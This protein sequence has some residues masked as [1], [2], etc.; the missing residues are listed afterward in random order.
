MSN[1]DDNNVVQVGAL[2]LDRDQRVLHAAIPNGSKLTIAVGQS[3]CG[4]SS[5]IKIS[6][7][8]L[9]VEW[10]DTKTRLSVNV[11]DAEHIT[12]YDLQW[13]TPFSPSSIHYLKD[14]IDLNGG[15]HW[16]GGPEL[17]NQTFPIDDSAYGM[18]PYV[19]GDVNNYG[20][21]GSGIERF[22]L[23]SN[24]M[25]VYVPQEVP[26]WVA[27]KDRHLSLQAQITDSVYDN[28]YSSQSP[29]LAYSLFIPKDKNVSLKDFLMS[30]LGTLY[31]KPTGMPDR[32]MIA[33][34][35]WTTWA[36][37]KAAISQESTLAYA[38]EIKDH[39]Y[40]ISQLELDDAWATKYGD[41]TFDP[42]KFPDPKGMI[43]KLRA[44]DIRLTIW[45]HP[46]I[47]KDSVNG[48]NPAL[49]PFFLQKPEG[50]PCEVSWWDGKEAYCVDFTNPSAADWFVAQLESLKQLGVH[51]FKFDAGETN[52]FPRKFKL[53]SGG[54]PNDFS[55]AYAKMASRMGED[56][57][58]RVFSETQAIPAF[59]RTLDRN[60]SWDNAGLK[61][62][63]PVAL[64]FSILGYPFNLPD[65]VG[66]NAYDTPM[67]EKEL[68]IRWMQANVFLLC[69]QLS[70]T[71]WQFDQETVDICDK[72]IKLRA[73]WT[74]YMLA[75]CEKCASTGLPVIRPLWWLGEHE[76]ALTCSRQFLVGDRLL[77]AIVV[78]KDVRMQSVLIPTGTWK[79]GIDGV[80]HQGPVLINQ[81]IPLDQLAFYVLQDDAATFACGII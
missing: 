52:Y 36:R 13:S 51:S 63:L 2:S 21:A 17:G 66:G 4:Q 73:E 27:H 53:F 31:D 29:T 34:P 55:R 41:F 50:G 70:F 25:V 16:Y 8:A 43:E 6:D 39:N 44:Q 38:Q 15:G 57:E 23:C 65:M 47:N 77:V 32:R 14:V 60:S 33:Q 30:V 19:T 68:F 45:I 7:E 3:I 69:M 79:C 67:P 62:V 46:F 20:A 26:L 5:I 11:V 10:S 12:R 49:F 61:T 40:P 22:W 71:P 56:I 76:E 72:M 54:S 1:G 64:N 81:V 28:F 80:V 78:D 18:F 37:Y 58:I 48:S 75:E 74:D 9:I 35:V 24:K 59:I 42:I